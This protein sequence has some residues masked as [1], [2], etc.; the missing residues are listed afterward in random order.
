MEKARGPINMYTITYTPKQKESRRQML[1]IGIRYTQLVKRELAK[2]QAEA[3]K[4][5]KKCPLDEL[6]AK[7]VRATIRQTFGPSIAKKASKLDYTHYKVSFKYNG[8]VITIDSREGD[9]NIYSIRLPEGQKSLHESRSLNCNEQSKL[10]ELLS[11]KS[12]NAF[13]AYGRAKFDKIKTVEELSDTKFLA[14]FK[15]FVKIQEDYTCKL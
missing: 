8:R 14:L 2:A 9:E 12:I 7:A 10:N 13:K 6:R 1:T 3:K 5:P 11:T 4:L 15:E